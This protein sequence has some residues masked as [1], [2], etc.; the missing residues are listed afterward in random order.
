LFH[1]PSGARA[2]K[3]SSLTRGRSNCLRGRGGR[4]GTDVACCAPPL[5]ETYHF[6]SVVYFSC[7][8]QTQIIVPR[9][10]QA[11]LSVGLVGRE[12]PSQHPARP[13]ATRMVP[14]VR[15]KAVDSVFIDG[16]DLDTV[17]RLMVAY[18]RHILHRTL[19]LYAQTS[20]LEEAFLANDRQ[21]TGQRLQQR[22][23][24]TTSRD[25]FCRERSPQVAG[26]FIYLL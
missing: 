9:V 10:V 11:P 26:Q 23:T 19:L 8:L 12:F 13:A 21:P 18:Q 16:P 5:V 24:I 22:A 20:S 2:C 7:H 6:K 3:R 25:T 17:C 15:F 1:L 4:M 14:T